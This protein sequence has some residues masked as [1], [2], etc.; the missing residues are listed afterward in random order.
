MRRPVKS[1]WVV[2]LVAV[3]LV[4]F[5]AVAMALVAM[6]CDRDPPAQGPPTATD[7]PVTSEGFPGDV[8]VQRIASMAPSITELLFALG[9]GE[10]VV[11]VTRYCDY[12]PEATDRA[13]IGGMLD[14]DYEAMLAAEPDLVLGVKDG[15]DHRMVQRLDA[16]GIAYGFLTADDLA[17]VRASMELLGE[18][19]GADEAAAELRRRFDDELHRAARDLEG[20]WTTEDGPPPGG[21]SSSITS[22]SSPPA[23]GPSPPSSSAWRA[24]RT[25]WATTSGPTRCSTWRGS[26]PWTPG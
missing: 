18:W 12:P 23:P 1:A 25:P 13:V 6:S 9:L 2:H 24:S 17:G 20:V 5:T 16:A 14:P 22:P 15:A 7:D 26:T 4:V 19:L 21:S 3:H 8:E 11:A 10:K